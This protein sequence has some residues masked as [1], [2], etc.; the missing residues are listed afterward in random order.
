MRIT[1]TILQHEFIG[2][3][4]EIADNLNPSCVGLHGRVLNE[5]RNM[6]VILHKGKK[7]LIAKNVAVF[8][9]TM[10]DGTV[11]EI[12]GKK[13]IGRPEHRIKKRVKR[14]W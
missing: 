8:H 11:V 9:F 12:D 6:L 7:R 2:L 4:A 13:I 10:P 1:P 3:D 14:R 5:T